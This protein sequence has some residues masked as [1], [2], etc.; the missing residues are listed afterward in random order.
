MDQD[1]TWYGARP[2]PRRLCVRWGPRSPPQKGGGAPLKFLAHVYCGQTAGRIKMPLSVM[3]GLGPGNVVLDVDPA[4]PT[5]KGHSP[6]FSAHVCCGQTEWC[7]KMT[8]GTKVG[9]GQ[10]NIVLHGDP[11]PPKMV[12]ASNFWP[13]YIMAKRSPITATGTGGYLYSFLPSNVCGCVQMFNFF[14]V[15]TG[16]ATT[17]CYLH[18]KIW[19][20]I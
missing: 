7:I 17:K 12:T 14:S 16:G 18:V 10:G 1:V 5:P 2:Q 8:L 3:I 20:K 6:Q 13:M 4:P 19:W 9:L 11:A 15:L